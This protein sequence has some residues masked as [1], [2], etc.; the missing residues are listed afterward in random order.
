MAISLEVFDTTL[1]CC[2]LELDKAL[3]SFFAISYFSFYFH[4]R[5]GDLVILYYGCVSR[6][7]HCKLLNSHFK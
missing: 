6:S 4:F 3:S 2:M 1:P 5:R 7:G